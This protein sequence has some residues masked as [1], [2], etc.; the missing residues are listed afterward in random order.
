[1]GSL[2]TGLG[3]ESLN[4]PISKMKK[5]VSSLDKFIAIQG[6]TWTDLVESKSQE[7]PKETALRLSM[8]V[9]SAL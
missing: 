6:N 4:F 5:T 8:A 1:M 7:A 2:S 9:S 3:I